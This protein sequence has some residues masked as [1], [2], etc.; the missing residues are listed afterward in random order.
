LDHFRT[1]RNSVLW[2]ESF[3]SLGMIGVQMANGMFSGPQ[4]TFTRKMLARAG[5][6]EGMQSQQLANDRLTAPDAM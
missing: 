3:D 2:I 6:G 4:Q 1:S 5:G